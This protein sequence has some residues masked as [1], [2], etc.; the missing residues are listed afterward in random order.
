MPD[1]SGSE[2]TLIFPHQLFERHPAVAAGRPIAL[3]E[4]SLFFGDPHHPLRRHTHKLLLH[5]A[6]MRAY[7]DE[8]RQAGH[9]VEPIEYR[10]GRTLREVIADLGRQGYRAFFV[11]E[12]VDFLLEKRL[13]ESVQRLGGEVRL[14]PTP[15]FLTPRRVLD[16][17]FGSHDTWRM[18]T[19][20]IMQRRRLGI[21][22]ERDKP[23]GGR[24]SFDPENRRRWPAGAVPP[25]LPD[26]RHL[27]WLPAL[28][29]AVRAEFPGHPGDPG[30]FWLPVTR[31]EARRWLID[32]LDHR[33]AEFGPYEDAMC[34]TEP[35]LCHSVLS[36]LLNI[37]LLT[38]A[39]VVE[40]TL[41]AAADRG[42]IPPSLGASL[43]QAASRRPRGGA[44]HPRQPP[45]TARR[46]RQAGPTAAGPE[47]AGVAP[48]GTAGRGPI[49]LASLE[50]FLRQVI[51]WREF[52]RGVYER[53]GV[54]ERTA[55]FF[56]HSRPLPSSFYEGTTGLTPLDIVIERIGRL[57]WCHHIE[58]LMVVGNAML[59]AGFHPDHV[60]RWFMEL[61][62]DAYDWVM[63]PNVYGM[64]QFAD[65]GLFATKPYISG[66]AYLR[67]L[68][69]FPGGPWEDL[70]DALFWQ[71][72]ATHQDFFDRQPRLA[73]MARQARARPPDQ[74][75]RHAALVAEWRDRTGQA[76]EEKA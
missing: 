32:F 21:L 31:R 6:T 56:G 35:V 66:S 46:R 67:R 22:L 64:S 5:R 41:A 37:G 63:V 33:L 34:A 50:G 38:P 57:G 8:L 23:V 43:P 3:V 68:G 17:Y 28:A 9:Q 12:P 18:A 54:A 70:W 65:G 52:I 39:E 61:F 45:A 42:V 4:D 44:A 51:G 16:D 13:H 75:A 24:W 62:V 25:P 47:A 60:Y 20:Y 74:I 27:E 19:F 10:P 71:F 73:M 11:A 29:R 40:A 72:I 59:L 55:N 49:P 1:M 26:V 53:A 7:A 30:T 48:S 76:L 36:P 14:C 2:I 69:D 15:L 58:R